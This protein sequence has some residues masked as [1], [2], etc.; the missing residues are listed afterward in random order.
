MGHR[1]RSSPRRCEGGNS[2]HSTGVHESQ[3]AVRKTSQLHVC[4]ALHL[5]NYKSDVD[6]TSLQAICR[7][8]SA[9]Q[10]EWQRA[11]WGSNYRNLLAIKDF[12]D[13]DGLFI[14]H[15]GVGS[16]RWSADGFTRQP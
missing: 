2:Y 8:Q 4:A 15:H 7:L 1:E 3:E 16:E 9:S 13:P 6:E 10:V 12:Y 11:Y 14:V 5:S